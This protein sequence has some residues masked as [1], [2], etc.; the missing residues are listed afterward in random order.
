LKQLGEDS[1]ATITRV[2]PLKESAGCRV[3]A[4]STFLQIE[5]ARRY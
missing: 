2:C 4:R 3:A 5:E 1:A